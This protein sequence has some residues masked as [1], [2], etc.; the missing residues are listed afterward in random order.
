M[1]GNINTMTNKFTIA[2][3]DIILDSL[4]YSKLNIEN[5]QFHPSYQYKLDRLSEI[6]NV[7]DKVREL[8]K[9]LKP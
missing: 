5:N 1:T 9:E 2:D 6:N 4:K 7:V 8:K 3:L